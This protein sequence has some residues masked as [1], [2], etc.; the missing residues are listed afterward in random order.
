MFAAAARGATALADE[1]TIDP[2]KAALLKAI[3]E[4]REKDP[5]IGAKIAGKEMLNRLLVAM[6]NEKGVH[7]ESLLTALGALAGFSCQMG[8]RAG[9]GGAQLTVATTKDGRRFFFGDALNAPLA[10]SPYSVWALCAGMAQHL[11]APLPDLDEIF[12]HVSRT[13]GSEDFGVPRFPGEGRAADLPINYVRA[14]WPNV[15]PLLSELCAGPAE[16]HI[17]TGLAAQEAI[18]ATKGVINPSWAV[19]IVME[20]AIPMSKLD[21]SEVGM[22]V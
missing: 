12:Q 21:P 7:A 11:G 2:R 19:K 9:G 10:E 4:Q 13:I 8:V 18:G 6:K 1:T 20:C 17:A 5:L 16:W 14:I 22:A 3:A 15:L